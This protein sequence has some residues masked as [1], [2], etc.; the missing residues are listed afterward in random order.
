M[1]TNQPNQNR[2]KSNEDKDEEI[3]ENFKLS[4]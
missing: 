1:M 2:S 3:K 4:S